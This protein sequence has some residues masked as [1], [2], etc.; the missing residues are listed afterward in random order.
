MVGYDDK[1]VL[2][3]RWNTTACPWRR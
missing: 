1:K 2:V 3:R